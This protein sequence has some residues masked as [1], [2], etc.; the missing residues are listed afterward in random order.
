MTSTTE[1]D[2]YLAAVPQPARGTLEGLR[3]VIRRLVPDAVEGFSYGIP[4]YKYR[5]RPLAYFG[6][7]K[8]H[9]ALY[10]LDA[11]L[12]EQAGYQTSKGTI[13]F[14]PDAPPPEALIKQLL[15]RRMAAIE[16]DEAARKQKRRKS[17]A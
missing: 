6:A 10:A 7:A 8:N 3:A 9:C 4:G 11:S 13:R 16:A 2:T 17:S 12:A 1:V 14:P 5:G 15:E